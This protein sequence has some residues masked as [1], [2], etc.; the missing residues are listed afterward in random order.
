[1]LMHPGTMLELAN[2]RNRDLIAEGDR[3][4]LLA[5]ARARFRR[6]RKAVRGQP[7][8]TVASCDPSVAVPAR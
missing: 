4:R 7:T 2:E 3:G 5:S 8:G 1:M 6:E